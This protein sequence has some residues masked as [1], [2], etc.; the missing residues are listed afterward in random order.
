[1][2]TLARPAEG[3]G[4]EVRLKRLHLA[5]FGSISQMLFQFYFL[6]WMYQ[7]LL[8]HLLP[9][10]KYIT[11]NKMYQQRQ[12]RWCFSSHVHMILVKKMHK[13]QLYDVKKI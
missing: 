9:E 11:N 7:P 12:R 5:K 2:P 6:G 10:H 13:N 4:I 8:T 1:M 3:G